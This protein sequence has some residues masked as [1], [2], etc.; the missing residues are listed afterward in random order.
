MVPGTPVRLVLFGPDDHPLDRFG[1]PV[2]VANGPARPVAQCLQAV[3][4]V[5]IEDLIPSLAGNAE[6]AADAAHR[7]AIE[8]PKDKAHPLFHH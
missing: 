4:P 3:L 5:T 1:K 2:S 6:R 8:Q 7:F